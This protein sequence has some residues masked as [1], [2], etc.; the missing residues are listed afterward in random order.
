VVSP[1]SLNVTWWIAAAI[2][3]MR[4]VAE[5]VEEDQTRMQ[6]EVDKQM[7]QR[8]AKWLA[9]DGTR[10]GQDFDREVAEEMD[11]EIRRKLQAQVKKAGNQTFY[12][13]MFF[14]EQCPL[15]LALRYLYHCIRRS[16]RKHG[17][18]KRDRQGGKPSTAAG[19]KQ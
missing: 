5:R 16:R 18:D 1:S 15:G 2:D 7:E 3:L 19:N 4:R 13:R 6:E 9:E 17:Y 10:V 11:S 12:T 8:K 14:D